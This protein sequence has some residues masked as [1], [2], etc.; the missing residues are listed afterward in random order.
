MQS[1]IKQSIWKTIDKL[2]E[3][4]CTA[5]LS[6]ISIA[7]AIYLIYYAYTG[8]KLYFIIPILLTILALTYF[9]IKSHL[10]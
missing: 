10:E 2:V 8:L 3:R 7:A 5:W 1:K 4:F 9:G 6:T